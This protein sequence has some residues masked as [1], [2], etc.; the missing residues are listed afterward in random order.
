MCFSHSDPYRCRVRRFNSSLKANF[1]KWKPMATWVK[2]QH[3]TS[4]FK[5]M[6]KKTAKKSK[7][8]HALIPREKLEHNNEDFFGSTIKV[9]STTN[10]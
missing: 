6:K 8:K 5:L 10:L 4:I 7:K 9:F 3:F 1:P 2:K